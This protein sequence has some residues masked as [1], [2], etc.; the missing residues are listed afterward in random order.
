MVG[1]QLSQL[2]SRGTRRATARERFVPRHGPT[3]LR[4]ATWIA[5][6]AVCLLLGCSR[7]SEYNE[8][9][10][11]TETQID[12][13]LDRFVSSCAH[14]EV[15]FTGLPADETYTNGIVVTDE[16]P[17]PEGEVEV[18]R[19]P[20]QPYER[21][22]NLFTLYSESPVGISIDFDQSRFRGQMTW[23]EEEQL[24]KVTFVVDY[25]SCSRET[26]WE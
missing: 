23:C 18:Y 14:R 24:R 12:H 21:P 9:E 15:D 6:M 1:T 19:V 22:V 13:A 11:R 4:C 5:A 25:E 10:R 17:E 7:R 8:N 26:I 3:E 2:S 16:C 20:V